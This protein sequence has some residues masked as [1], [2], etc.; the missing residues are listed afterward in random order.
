[1]HS[2]RTLYETLGVGVHL[3][4]LWRGLE[5]LDAVGGEDGVE[6][7]G[8]AAVAQQVAETGRPFAEVVEEV[9]GELGG[10][11]GGQVGGDAE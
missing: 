7:L 11:G 8:V 9:A 4:R 6:G 3:R 1:V 5:D 2:A 10:P